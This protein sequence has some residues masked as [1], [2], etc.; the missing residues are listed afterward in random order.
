MN[1]TID[2]VEYTPITEKKG[3]VFSVWVVTDLDG[4]NP[5]VYGAKQTLTI[6]RVS[7]RQFEIRRF[8]NGE[9]LIQDA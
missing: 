2:G 1:V 3:C 9:W 8:G 7:R 6:S 4:G 5:A